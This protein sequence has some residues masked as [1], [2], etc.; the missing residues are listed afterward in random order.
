MLAKHASPQVMELS[1]QAFPGHSELSFHNINFLLPLL[2][3]PEAGCQIQE[4]LFILETALRVPVHS[5]D[6]SKEGRPVDV[7]LLIAFALVLFRMLNVSQ[8]KETIIT[9]MELRAHF[10][11]TLAGFDL[12]TEFLL[13]L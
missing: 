5:S 7:S 11:D 13:W 1:S 2:W 12:V 3:R 4:Q 9:A 8:I 6:N 10:P